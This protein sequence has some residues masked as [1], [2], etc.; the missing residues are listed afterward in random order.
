MNTNNHLGVILL[1]GLA[2]FLVYSSGNISMFIDFPAAIVIILGTT[3]SYFLAES[4][5]HKG[6]NQ[7]LAAGH[8]A[9]MTGLITCII[10]LILV[11]ANLENPQLIGPHLALGLISLLYGTTIF[12]VCRLL[13]Y[14]QV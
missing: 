12:M 9:W 1:T 14:R 3:G 8:G 7:L 2:A 5:E 10:S 4:S 6:G 11:L 13:S